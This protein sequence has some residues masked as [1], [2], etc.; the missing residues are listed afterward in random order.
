MPHCPSCGRYV[1]P[2]Q[3]CPHCGARLSGRIPIP[4]IKIVAAVLATV[5]LAALWL[6]ATRAEVPL[7]QIGQV[8]A[9]MNLAYVRLQGH[10]T[11]TPSYDPKSE[12]L[13]FWLED[14]TGEI[15]ISAYRA[16]TRQLLAQNHVPALGD[17][18]E[19]AGTLRVRE[20]WLSLTLD[21]PEQLKISRAKPV[22]R[23]IGSI[24][25]ED[26]YLRVRV[27]GQVRSVRA[28]YEGLTLITVRD[29][30]G[31]IPI[32][33]SDDL[34]ALSGN[35]STAQNLPNSAGPMTA[36]GVALST[37]QPVE[38]VAAVSLY[39][40]TPQLIPASLAAIARLGEPV[41]IAAAKPIGQLTSAD[42][43]QLAAVRGTVT[44]ADSF[45][46]GV[47]LTLDDTT[48]AVIALLWQSVYDEL[49]D[50]TALDVGAE[51][52]VRGE[53]SRYRGELELIPELTDDVRL[54]ATAPPP[55]EMT[56]GALTRADLGQVV[57]LRGTLG[58]PDVFSAGVKFPLDDG[59]GQVSLLLWDDVHQHAPQELEAGTQVVATGQVAAYQ[60]ELELIPRN[61]GEIRVT[62]RATATPSGATP[63]PTPTPPPTATPAVTPTQT[64]TATPGVTPTPDLEITPIGAITAGHVGQEATVEGTVIDAASF[65]TGFKFTLDDG[66]GQIELLMWHPVYDDCWDAPEINLGAQVRAMGEV[67]QYEG[68]LQIQ[69]AFGGDVQVVESTA[70]WATPREIG[71]LTAGD[72]GQRVMI[73]GQVVRVEGVRTAVK[74]FIR[75]DTGETLVF[76]WRTTLDR[77]PDNA[78]LGT[79]G[80]RVRVIG[81][82]E[83]YQGNLEVVPTLPNDVVVLAMP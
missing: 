33:V 24:G 48:G 45:S 78:A 68:V 39:G 6:L 49:P 29:E 41:R 73:E 75:D 50:P 74:V 61:A 5:G 66:T 53:V 64:T 15:R 14:D 16:E 55:A 72:E 52:Q 35:S 51:I 25:P 60:D 2:C 42:V 22:D 3:A 58:P 69:P 8:G 82:V 80:S 18:V 47:K 63:Q 31:A 83:L 34:L 11:Q 21:V 57:T 40:D 13:S 20:D 30:T 56:V 70:A 32:A 12:V 38:V 36:H 1:A 27:R 46:A 4:F 9:T 28:P 19:V 44:E 7:V 81:M 10:C 62:G 37:G 77:I 71:T 26:Q 67:G 23:A 43:G 17:R 65:S 79:P 59:T 76:V 54:L